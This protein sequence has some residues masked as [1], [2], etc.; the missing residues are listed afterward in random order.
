[1]MGWFAVTK[2][3]VYVREDEGLDAWREKVPGLEG[4]PVDLGNNGGL[5]IAGEEEY[6]HKVA[7]DLVKG[8]IVIDF[9]SLDIQGGNI[10]VDNPRAILYMCEETNIL[11]EFQHRKTTKPDKQ[12]NYLITYDPMIFRPIW[13]RR[14]ISTLPGP[15]VVMGA[16]TTT[17]SDQGKRNVKKMVSL[18]PDGRVGIS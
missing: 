8:I 7:V 5:L 13:F 18:F 9:D 11:G 6:G 10:A 14:H 3:K 2:D 12:G 17:P 16:Q 4:R 15:V 1:M